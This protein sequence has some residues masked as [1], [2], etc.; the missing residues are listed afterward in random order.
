VRYYRGGPTYARWAPLASVLPGASARAR[1]SLKADPNKSFRE[2]A[3]KQQDKDCC[4]D[5][6]VI[7]AGSF[8]MGRPAT[9]KGFANEVPQH[10]VTIAKPFAVSKFKLTFDEWD[11]FAR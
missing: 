1:A 3:P 10:T 6:V 8:M 2:C 11:T 5:M 7:P 9:K 4:P